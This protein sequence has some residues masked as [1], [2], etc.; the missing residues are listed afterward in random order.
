MCALVCKRVQV[1]GLGLQKL[2]KTF[3]ID[4]FLSLLLLPP[5]LP[6]NLTPSPPLF[7]YA[8]YIKEQR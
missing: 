4:H 7:V 8:A 1:L 6:P 3:S 5:P 2:L